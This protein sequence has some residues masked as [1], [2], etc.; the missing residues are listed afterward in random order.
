MKSLLMEAV[1]VSSQ[2]RILDGW[3]KEKM[4][5]WK[6]GVGFNNFGT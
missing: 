4:E 1:H 2:T 3:S 5:I 6:G